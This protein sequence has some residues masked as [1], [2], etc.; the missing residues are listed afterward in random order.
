VVISS[1]GG[2]EEEVKINYSVDQG[3]MERGYSGISF[4]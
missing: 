3:V 2:E 1:S 4:G